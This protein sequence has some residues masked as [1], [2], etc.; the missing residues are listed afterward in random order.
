MKIIGIG[1]IVWDMLPQG[2]QLGGAP[3]NFAH[4]AAQLGAEAYAVSAVGKDRLGDEALAAA[5]KTSVDLS[6]IQRRDLPTSRV[7]ITLDAAGIPQYEI[8]ENVAWDDLSCSEEA[9][10]LMSDA[11]VVCWGSLAQRSPLSRESILRLIDAAP[12]SC[13]RVFDINIRQHYY[14]REIIEGSLKRT[15]ILKLNEDEL[16]LVAQLLGLEK[17]IENLFSRFGLRYLVHTCG[18]SHSEVYGPK[19]LLS[20]LETP[21]VEVVDTV[22]AGDSFTAA[23]VTSLLNGESVQEAHETAVRVSAFVCTCHGAIAPLP[24]SLI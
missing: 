22:G 14:S 3:L 4:F 8:V 15:D 18:A 12:E 6:Y 21:K 1:E 17:P 5:A 2:K 24:Q 11:S 9:L 13:L 10:S 7:L 20:R 23:F 19:G 16:P